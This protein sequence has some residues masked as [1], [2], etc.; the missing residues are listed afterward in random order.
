[1]TSGPRPAGADRDGEGD[2]EGDRVAPAAVGDPLPAAVAVDPVAADDV[3]EGELG[4]DDPVGD[5]PVDS[6]ALAVAGAPVVEP[7]PDRARDTPTAVT[8]ASNTAAA[9]TRRTRRG[10]PACGRRGPVTSPP[11]RHVVMV[12]VRRFVVAGRSQ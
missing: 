3:I 7:G 8:T 2:G 1:V 6:P 5:C 12:A 4:P 9:R 10:A 11:V